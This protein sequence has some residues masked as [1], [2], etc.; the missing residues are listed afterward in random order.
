MLRTVGGFPASTFVKLAYES[1]VI[2]TVATVAGT[3][4]RWN[5]NSIYD[6]DNTGVGHQPRFH[7]KW[8]Q[9]YKRYVVYACKIQWELINSGTFPIIFI[10]N[11]DND[12]SLQVQSAEGAELAGVRKVTILPNQTK[13]YYITRYMRCKD[14]AGTNT[15]DVNYGYSTMGTNP[16]NLI[17]WVGTHFSYD[18]ATST[19]LLQRVRITYYCKL[20]ELGEEAKS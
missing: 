10:T 14:V 3:L 1:N 20:G 15:N 19:T 6:P 2:S 18:V 13:P 4:H 9:I 17:Y 5:A 12:T 8:S 11:W 7:D 16:T